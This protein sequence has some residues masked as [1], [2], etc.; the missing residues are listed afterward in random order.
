MKIHIANI[1][2]KIGG[3]WVQ[4]R[5]LGEGLN[6]VP[7]EE[8][9]IYFVVGAT[10]AERHEVEQAK[11]DGKKIVLRVDN[12]LRNSANRSTGM[13]RLKDFSDMAD[14]VIYQSHWAKS[15]LYDFT[16]RDGA[17]ILNGVDTSIFNTEGRTSEDE[18]YLYSRTSRDE[19]KGWLASWYWYV[20][21]AK[22]ESRLDI[23]GKFSGENQEHN[24]DFYNNETYRFYGQVRQPEVFFKKNKYFLYSYLNDAMSNT[25]IEALHS[26]CEIINIYGMLDT[27]GAPEIMIAWETDKNI[28]TK[29]YMVEQYRLELSRLL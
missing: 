28:L 4:A 2:D 18:T 8:A 17:V 9:D 5:Y 29:E 10:Q 26:G 7:Y 13:T 6:H 11:Q 16:K 21:H 27:G 25:L 23:I 22:P 12:I 15:F 24:F 20:E 19:N 1:T 3:G 14:L